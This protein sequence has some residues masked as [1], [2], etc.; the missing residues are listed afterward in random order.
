M[1]NCPRCSTPF[2]EEDAFCR[3]CGAPAEMCPFGLDWVWVIYGTALITIFQFVLL[4][5]ASMSFL[6]EEFV[7]V[8]SRPSSGLLGT[9]ILHTALLTAAGYLV[10]GVL[11][12]RMSAGH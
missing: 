8:L 10:G 11:V 1:Q 12:G 2:T 4:A 7:L 6:G 5:V 3:V 9:V